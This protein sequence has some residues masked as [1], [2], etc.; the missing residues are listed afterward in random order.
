MDKFSDHFMARRIFEFK[1]THANLKYTEASLRRFFRFIEGLGF[2]KIP[3]GELSII[4]MEDASIAQLHGDYL[5]DPTPT[6][7]ITFPGDL[8]MDFAGEICISVDHALSQAG[9]YGH[10]PKKELTLYLVHGYL[11]LAGLNDLNEQDRLQMRAAE[12]QL[13]AAI[14]RADQ[15]PD[16]SFKRGL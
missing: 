8:S 11:H 14:D 5:G 4:F 15:Y 16:F 13:M 7:V 12:A 3:K 1:N 10:T 2:F 6:D 9:I